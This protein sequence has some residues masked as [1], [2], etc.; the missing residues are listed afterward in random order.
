MSAERDRPRLFFRNIQTV[1]AT[2]NCNFLFFIFYALMAIIQLSNYLRRDKRLV[3]STEVVTIC[4]HTFCLITDC[5][6]KQKSDDVVK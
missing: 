5:K 4:N 2:T 6:T 3:V 1:K